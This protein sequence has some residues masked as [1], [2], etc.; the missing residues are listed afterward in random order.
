MLANI[1]APNLPRTSLASNTL[2][3]GALPRW[4]GVRCWVGLPS[5]LGQHGHGVAPQPPALL[6]HLVVTRVEILLAFPKSLLEEGRVTSTTKR[7]SS[8]G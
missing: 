6:G 4:H 5:G 2:D 3:D 1:L 7:T 8:N